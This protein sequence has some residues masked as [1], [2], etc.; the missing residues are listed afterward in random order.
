[1]EITIKIVNTPHKKGGSMI[2]GKEYYVQIN[3][4]NNFND[5][6][7][8]MNDIFS[9]ILKIPDNITFSFMDH[10]FLKLENNLIIKNTFTSQKTLDI[11]DNDEHIFYLYFHCL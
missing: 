5:L 1:M 2:W 3:P 11:I 8:E 4:E 9:K 7:K 10:N 6:K